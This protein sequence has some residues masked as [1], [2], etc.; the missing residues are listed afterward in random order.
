MRNSQRRQEMPQKWEELLQSEEKYQDYEFPRVSIVIPTYN[1]TEKI[2]L[3]LESVLNQH[4]PDFEIIT[5]DAGSTDRT[6]EVIKNFRD[7]RIH[8]YSV[9]GFQRYEMLNKGV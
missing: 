9:S 7:E 5:V 1:S 6:L 8:I 3:T 4:Y 2:S